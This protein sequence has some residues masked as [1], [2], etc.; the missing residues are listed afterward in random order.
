[1]A[2]SAKTFSLEKCTIFFGTPLKGGFG[3]DEAIKITPSGDTWSS[4]DGVDGTTAWAYTG[5]TKFKVEISLLQTSSMN[6]VL[7]AL[8]YVQRETGIAVPLAYKDQN[9]LDLFASPAAI[10]MKLPE[11]GR[12]NKIA[13]QKWEIEAANGKLFLGGN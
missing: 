11:M 5:S 1:M 4:E 6:A 12:G 13:N 10:I 3:S 7:S 2:E 8:Y 9:G